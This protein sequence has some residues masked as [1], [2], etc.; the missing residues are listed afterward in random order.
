MSFSQAM[1]KVMV[2]KDLKARDLV[3]DSVTPQYLSK[4]ING[5][6]KDPT[7]DKACAIIDKLGM[8]VDEFHK[9]E[10]S[11]PQSPTGGGLANPST[12]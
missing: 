4:L 2:E 5:K 6:V 8:T 3:C 11:L 9:L 10:S 1:K 7:W 12:T